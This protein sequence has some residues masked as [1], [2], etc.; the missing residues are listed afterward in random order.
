MLLLAL[1]LLRPTWVFIDAKI[2]WYL[3]RLL[4]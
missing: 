3:K 4:V 1:S 2:N